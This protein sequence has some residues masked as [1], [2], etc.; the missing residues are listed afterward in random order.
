MAAGGFIHLDS[1]ETFGIGGE[2]AEAVARKIDELAG[3]HQVFCITH[4]PQIARFGDQHYYIEK[5]VQNDRTITTIRPMGQEERIK[6]IEGISDSKQDLASLQQTAL[7]IGLMVA[8]RR[9]AQ[10]R[11]KTLIRKCCLAY[12]ARC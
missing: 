12:F 4:L 11:G 7:L 9:Y 1:D 3:H 2:A 10:G 5:Q 6:E 8:R